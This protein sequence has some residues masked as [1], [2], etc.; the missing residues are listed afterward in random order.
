MKHLL[1]LLLAA[2]AFAGTPDP[3]NPTPST[4]SSFYSQLKKW[5]N[6]EIYNQRR[7]IGVGAYFVVCGCLDHAGPG[8]THTPDSCIAYVA[9]YRVTETQAITYP[10]SS[11]CCVVLEQGTVGDITAPDA[12]LWTRV[13]NTHY[14]LNCTGGGQA[15]LTGVHIFTTH[16]AG[17]SVVQVDDFRPLFPVDTADIADGAITPSKLA[18]NSSM[19][20]FLVA[21][22]N[23]ATFG[24]ADGEVTMASFAPVTTRGGLVQISCTWGA[25]IGF[26]PGSPAADF[27]LRLRRDGVEIQEIRTI[28]SGVIVE[29]PLPAPSLSD[30]P[31]TAGTYTYAISGELQNSVGTVA[32]AGSTAP[33]YCVLIEH[34]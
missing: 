30:H 28:L 17:G 16:T 6:N 13:P 33:G 26:G 24:P 32:V 15:P 3:I 14:M 21:Q 12:T 9:G 31:T 4:G 27:V 19:A 20:N 23:F 11:E 29:V 34:S 7:E 1:A 25:S 8:L 18:P 22:V 10:D 2:S 5:I